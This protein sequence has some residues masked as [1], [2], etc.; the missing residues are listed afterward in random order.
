[1]SDP[2]TDL[3]RLANR[4]GGKIPAFV[5]AHYVHWAM[6]ERKAAKPV[7]QFKDR[8]ANITAFV[9]NNNRG[10]YDVSVR[11]D[12]AGEYLPYA[13][14]FN[15]DR[16]AEAIE[17][18]RKCANKTRYVVMNENTLGYIEG[19]GK[20]M[21][22]LAG[23]VLKGGHSWLTG[24]VPVLSQNLRD[25]TTADFAEYRVKVPPN[26]EDAVPQDVKAD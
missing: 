2:Y 20:S 16:L 5:P 14:P 8:D 3:V 12:D 26:F 9:K 6:S 22:V 23:S 13:K 15:H 18:A 17:Y 19:G 10:G 25:A 24:S 1:M 11:D 21:G 7:A 4:N